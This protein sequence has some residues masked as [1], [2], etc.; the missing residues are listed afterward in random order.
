MKKIS[1][2]SHDIPVCHEADIVIAGGSCTGV[3]AAVRAARL[4][5]RVALIEQ[6]SLLGGTATAALVNHWHRLDDSA[7]NNR[8]I[9]G[10]TWEVVER[11]T[12]RGACLAVAGHERIRYKLNAAELAI[13]LDELVR[14]AG[15]IRPFLAAR[16]V[17][18]VVSGD[19]LTAVVIEDESGRRAITGQVFIDATGNGNLVR[20]AGGR[21]AQHAPLQ[22]VSHQFLATG[23]QRVLEQNP[24]A[25][26]WPE[27][28]DAALALGLRDSNPWVDIVPGASHVQTVFG[29]RLNGVDGSDADQLTQA[30]I[31]GRRH[32]RVFLDL[33]RQHYGATA[34]DVA[35]L[36]LPHQIGI[37]D[38]WHA[39][40]LHRVTADELL[41]GEKFPD[42]IGNGTYPL[43]IHGPEGT[44]IRYLDGKEERVSKQGETSEHRWR[45]EGEPCPRFYQ[46]PFRALVPQG[47]SNLLVA[48][49]ILD[50]DR[51]AYGGL[52]VMVNTNQTGEAAGVAAHIALTENTHVPQVNAASLR[53]LLSAGGSIML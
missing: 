36:A 44:S 33:I 12:R 18:P 41:R 31:E 53:S 11:L 49:R 40:C 46:I 10:L 27:I 13:E 21:A 32:A 7:R 29:A 2:P 39:C 48:G 8:V 45:K 20:R 17:Q 1:F 9:G 50:A 19:R 42:A 6:A 30:H 14:E 52:R 25:R 47:F 23:I 16:V 43:D 3:F 51:S 5:A 35:L 28:R 24:G 22:P 37:R 4:G 34:A 26:L 15:T 38:S